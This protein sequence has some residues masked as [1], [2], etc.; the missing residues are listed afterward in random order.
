[1]AEQLDTFTFPGPGRRSLYPWDEW[2]DG[3]VWRLIEGEDFST[4]PKA[5]MRAA[6]AAGARR[7]LTVQTTS[8][9]PAV[10][11]QAQAAAE[12]A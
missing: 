6:N 1:M 12:A 2:L 4:S 11:I 3:S 9:G 8:D 7:G 10:V 5:F